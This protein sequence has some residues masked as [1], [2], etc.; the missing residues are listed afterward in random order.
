M[1][2][3]EY[4]CVKC[5]DRF[6]YFQSMTDVSLK[7]CPACKGSVKRMISTGTGLIF[8]GGGFYQ[9]DYKGSAPASGSTPGAAKGPATCEK[10]KSC[11]DCPKNV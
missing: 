3:Y 2:T 6:E 9:T 4:E 7:K 1:P 8:K 10:S 5:G 11:P